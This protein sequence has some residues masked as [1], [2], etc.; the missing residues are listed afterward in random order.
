M[1]FYILLIE[2]SICAALCFALAGCGKNADVSAASTTPPPVVVERE[3][4]GG[5]IV[6][7]HPEKFPLVKAGQRADAPELNVTGSVNPDVSRN[8]PVISLASG[9]VVEIRARIGDSVTKGQLLM[10]VQSSDISQA[11]SDY[12]Q[13][14]A[15]EK[16]TSAQLSRATLLYD[17]GAIAQKDVEVAEDAEVKAKVTVENT[18]ER[19]RLLGADVNQPSSLV[20]IYAPVSGVI[21]EQNVTASAG[22]KTLDNSPNLFTISDNSVVWVICDV[23]ENDLP[24][25]HLDEVADIHLNAYPKM[26]LKGRVSNIGPVLD[27]NIRTAKVRLEVPNPGVLR[28]GMFVT[29]TFHGLSKEVRA[30]VPASAILH[31]HDRDWVYVPADGGRFRR[32]EVIGGK[33]LPENLQ[34]IVSG[35]KPGQQVVSRALIFQNTTEQ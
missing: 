21:T 29:A 23:F 20:D 6:V 10:R 28:F 12:R 11:F 34:E 31:L 25:V 14:V 32:V 33:M 4:N 3:E 26:I 7:D 30:T 8:I 17:K 15:D 13:A 16:L 35:L 22:V 5:M 9:R 1:K 18:T 27:P 24:S 2:T 19:L